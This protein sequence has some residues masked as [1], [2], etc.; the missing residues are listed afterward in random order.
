MDKEIITKL[1]K[2]FEDCA[3]EADGIEFWF[4]RDLQ[5]LLGYE[6]WRNF[7]AVIDKAKES[8]KNAGQIVA[9]HFA[10]VSKKVKIGSEAE[11]E[12]I[13]IGNSMGFTLPDGLKE[14]GVKVGKR[15]KTE[16]LGE[17]SFKV[18]IV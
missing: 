8:C 3:R 9:D 17:K 5:E 12:I 2:S 1:Q 7:L 14:F 10:G 4:A 6:Q 11:R 15:I 18:E 16:A 13:R